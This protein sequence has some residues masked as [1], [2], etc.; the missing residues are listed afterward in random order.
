V[1]RGELLS[2]GELAFY[3]V[4][5]AAIGRDYLITFKVRAADII[6]C[7]DKSWKEGFG[8]MVA[9]HHLDYVLCDFRSTRILAAIELDDRSHEEVRRKRR[10]QFLNDAF[11]A[12][13]VPLI[14]FRAA[15]R[16]APDEIAA[17][18]HRQVAAINQAGFRA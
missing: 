8:F 13:Q 10:D 2:R 15:A 16:Y 14:R 3:R 9:R 4:L 6:S 11:A 5:R 7:G 18:I 17:E 12:A 1:P